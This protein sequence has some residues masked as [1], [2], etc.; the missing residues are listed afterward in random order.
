MVNYSPNFGFLL[1]MGYQKVIPINFCLI[2]SLPEPVATAGLEPLALGW[3]GE[4]PTTVLPLLANV[5]N[6]W[7]ITVLTLAFC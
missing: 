4:C 5:R 2:F 3:Q 6:K 7:L 1:G